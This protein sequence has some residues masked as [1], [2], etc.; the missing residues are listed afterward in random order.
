MLREAKKPAKYSFTGILTLVAIAGIAYAGW[1]SG[2]MESA[3]RQLPRSHG[4]NEVQ[5]VADMLSNTPEC[6]R[7]RAA[8]LQYQ[9]KPASDELSARLTSLYHEGVDAGCKRLDVE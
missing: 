5:H 4:G 6:A 3:W 1:K 2:L 8:I 7:Y 9:G